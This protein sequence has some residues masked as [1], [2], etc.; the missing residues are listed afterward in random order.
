M[1][2]FWDNRYSDKTYAYGVT[3]NRFFEEQLPNFIPGTILLPGDG[4]GRNGVFAARSGWQVTSVDLS[5]QGKYKAL[6]LA[7]TA[8]VKLDYLVGD[9]ETLPFNPASFD[10]IGLIYAHFTAGS[11]AAIH[12]KLNGYLKPGGILIL[13]AFRKDHLQYNEANASIGGPKELGMLYSADELLTSFPDYD[14]LILEDKVIGLNEGQYHQGT[15][16]VVRYV[17]R[18]K[19]L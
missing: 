9:I 12:Q 13:E 6:A 4:E 7:E 17:G 1:E 11:K 18:K 5:I 8:K 2:K 19:Q 16:A 15:G 3:P 14:I 10:A